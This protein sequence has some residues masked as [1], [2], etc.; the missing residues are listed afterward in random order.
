MVATPAS[1]PS[2]AEPHP[3]RTVAI[4][5]LIA[6]ALDGT[7]A[8]LVYGPTP[9]RLFQSVASGLLGSDSYQGGIATGILGLVLHFFIATSAAAVFLLASRRLPLLVRRAAPS[10]VAYGIA[11]YFFMRLV[12]LPL[13]AATLRPLT[14]EAAAKGVAIHIV[15]IGLPIALWI[16]HASSKRASAPLATRAVA[17]P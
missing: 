7:A 16:R 17:A 10:G 9:L 4:A 2:P 8:V 1:S 6:G 15:C 12:V 14:L 11:V 3:L 13:S 5:G